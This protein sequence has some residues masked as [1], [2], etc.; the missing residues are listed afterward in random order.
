[1]QLTA[2]PLPR[3]M[4]KLTM[5]NPGC[6]VLYS[7]E[8]GWTTALYH[9]RDKSLRHWAEPKKPSRGSMILFV[10]KDRRKLV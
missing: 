7:N 10:C 2:V 9:H 8:K 6:G 5:N 3:R 4:D 1:M